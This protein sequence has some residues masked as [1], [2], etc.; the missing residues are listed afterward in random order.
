MINVKNANL[1]QIA[2]YLET[3]EPSAP[4]LENRLRELH[5]QAEEMKSIVSAL[6]KWSRKYPKGMIHPMSSNLHMER[7]LEAIEERAKRITPPEDKP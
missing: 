7:G 5:E 1:L 6:A 4:A 3:G 2:S